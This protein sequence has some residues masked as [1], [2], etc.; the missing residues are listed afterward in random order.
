MAE[1]FINK[2]FL[3]FSKC[4]ISRQDRFSLTHILVSIRTSFIASE[5]FIDYTYGFSYIDF[6]SS[7]VLTVKMFY[8]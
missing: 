3:F 2:F 6:Y 5:R 1:H 4:R 7:V 8:V